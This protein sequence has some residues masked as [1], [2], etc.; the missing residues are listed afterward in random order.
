M[1]ETQTPDLDSLVRLVDAARRSFDT[2]EPVRGWTNGDHRW[3]Q[4]AMLDVRDALASLSPGWEERV[5]SGAPASHDSAPARMPCLNCRQGIDESLPIAIT[6]EGKVICFQC[7]QN[8][9]CDQCGGPR[10]IDGLP[11]SIEGDGR[12]ICGRCQNAPDPPSG[13]SVEN[14]AARNALWELAKVAD[15]KAHG[16]PDMVLLAQVNEAIQYAVDSVLAAISPIDSTEF[17][18]GREAGFDFCCGMLCPMC[19]EGDTPTTTGVVLRHSDGSV[20]HAEEIRG[21]ANNCGDAEETPDA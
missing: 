2:A 9:A 4:I 19:A 17:E 1:P 14:L 5:G 18:R 21:G 16:K 15:P 10:Q 6:W 3:E 8:G 7:Y 20:C 11:V 13:E 12:I